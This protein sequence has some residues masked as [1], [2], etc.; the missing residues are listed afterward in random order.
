MHIMDNITIFG[1]IGIYNT[2]EAI[3]YLIG[4]IFSIILLALSITAYR[5]M[6]LKKIKY[7]MVAFGLFAAYLLSEY[8][9]ITLKPLVAT[10]SAE[11]ILPSMTLAI[12]ALFFLAIV[13]KN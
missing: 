13:K 8:L 4:A 11:F 6:G 9:E 5:N 3:I 7:A 2:I 1:S 12:V 10:A